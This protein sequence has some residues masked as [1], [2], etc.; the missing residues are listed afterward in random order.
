MVLNK[1]NQQLSY[2]IYYLPSV[3]LS[4]LHL[5]SCLMQKP[6]VVDIQVDMI[7]MNLKMQRLLLQN[8]ALAGQ[9]KLFSVLQMPLF[10]MHMISVCLKGRSYHTICRVNVECGKEMEINIQRKQESIYSKL[11]ALQ[12]SPPKCFTKV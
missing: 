9:N 5:M 1:K 3:V 4:A 8:L 7:S 11:Y 12:S 6:H 2:N 10:K